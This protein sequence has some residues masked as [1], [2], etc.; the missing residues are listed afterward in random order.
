MYNSSGFCIYGV[1]QPSQFQNSFI[2]PKKKPVINSPGTSSASHSTLPPPH[3]SPHL[4]TP[5]HTSLFPSHLFIPSSPSPSS[6]VWRR[7]R[8]LSL[9]TAESLNRSFCRVDL[10]RTTGQRTAAVSTRL[11]LWA[12][13]TDEVCVCVCIIFSIKPLVLNHC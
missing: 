4:P 12:T 9:F 5:P 2:T 6:P 10:N 8:L 11:S 3:T 13:E 1:V 7:A